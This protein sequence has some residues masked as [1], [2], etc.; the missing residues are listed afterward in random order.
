[1]L[2]VHG[3][4]PSTADSQAAATAFHTMS[5]TGYGLR[6]HTWSTRS[7]WEP[8]SETADAHTEGDRPPG[9][10]VCRRIFPQRPG[11]AVRGPDI[12]ELAPHVWA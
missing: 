8:S 5:R 10:Y 4:S 2:D 1:M 12:P 7:A 3:D 11:M 9:A 6:Q